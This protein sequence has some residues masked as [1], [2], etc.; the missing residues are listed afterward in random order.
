MYRDLPSP[1]WRR[2]LTLVDLLIA[3]ALVA[4]VVVLFV[5]GHHRQADAIL[6]DP[7]RTPGSSTRT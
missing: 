4:A 1:R 7:V 3:L 6:A 5:H 2:P